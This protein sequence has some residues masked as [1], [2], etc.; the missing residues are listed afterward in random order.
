MDKKDIQSKIMG[1]MISL[2]FKMRYADAGADCNG[3]ISD[4]CGCISSNRSDKLLCHDIIGDMIIMEA[5]PWY[6]RTKD[7]NTYMD[8]LLRDL[9]VI[10]S[11]EAS[12][13]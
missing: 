5:P 8:S 2:G 3:C 6:K 11:I 1:R 7:L 9:S 12:H 10:K 13:G 4:D